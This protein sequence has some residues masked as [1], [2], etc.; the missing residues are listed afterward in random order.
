M[1][2]QSQIARIAE[3]V[4]TEDVLEELNRLDMAQLKIAEIEQQGAA[5][6]RGERFHHLDGEAQM[7]VHPKFFHYWGQRLG[8]DCWNDEQFMREF[9]RDNPEVRIKSRSRNIT[10]GYRGSSKRRFHKSYGVL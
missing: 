9:Q 5:K 10:I 3:E 1:F 4:T 2:T 6:R 7:Q 8:Y